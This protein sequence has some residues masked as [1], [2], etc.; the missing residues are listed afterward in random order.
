MRFADGGPA[1]RYSAQ[2]ARPVEATSSDGNW[3]KT[4]KAAWATSQMKPKPLTTSATGGIPK[5]GLQFF[6]R[7][8]PTK[9][10][11]DTVKLR[12]E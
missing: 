9:K 12:C 6:H 7:R 5:K 11:N 10:Q 8:Y 4:K 1:G 3:H 2:S